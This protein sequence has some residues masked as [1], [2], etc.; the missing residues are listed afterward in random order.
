MKPHISII[1]PVYNAEETIYPTLKSILDQTFESIEVIVVDDGSVD[2]TLRILKR[3]S[4]LDSRIK[5]LETNAE[6]EAFAENLGL[7]SATGKY[8]MFF[9]TDALMSSNLFE[10]FLPIIE[11]R[12][13]GIITC[14]YFTTT[15]PAF[16]NCEPLE[17]PK[18]EQ[19]ILT[20]LDSNQYLENLSLED[21]HAFQST[22]VLWNK[23][24]DRSF[25][26]N[27]KFDTTKKI[28][29]P[30][31]SQVLLSSHI[32]TVVSNQKLI[33]TTT[34]DDFYERISFNYD[35]LDK[36]DFLQNLLVSYKQRNNPTAVKNIAIKLLALL[37]QIRMKLSGFCVDIYDL[38]EQKTNINKKFS[39]IR[40]FLKSRYPES[41]NEYEHYFETF[42]KILNCEKF[43][44]N[45]QTDEF[46]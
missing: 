16:H 19:E 26:T 17:A 25:L 6:G 32:P 3:Y 43:I 33:V 13:C 22:C 46:R 30:F 24:I 38:D 11:K 4:K 23:L 42:N 44:E 15:E 9:K 41:A 36:I 28:P 20:T 5:L 7:Q 35:E 45:K 29:N 2:N 14:D 34:V 1:M 40:K 39:S 31:A 8:I 18:Q 37:V 12:K 21:N 10:Y 27:F